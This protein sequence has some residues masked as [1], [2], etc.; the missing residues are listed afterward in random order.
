[1]LLLPAVL[2]AII[3]LDLALLYAAAASVLSVLPSYLH[4]PM[5]KKYWVATVSQED[6]V[7]YSSAASPVFS[8]LLVVLFGHRQLCGLV[9]SWTHLATAGRGYVL[10]SMMLTTRSWM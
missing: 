7:K 9:Y 8:S 2:A 1:V 4:A 3:F 6:S 5:P 10:A